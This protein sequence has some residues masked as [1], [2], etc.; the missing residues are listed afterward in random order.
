MPGTLP[1]AVPGLGFDDSYGTLTYGVRSEA[2]GF[3]VTTGSSVTVGQQGG[4][5][6][7][8]FLNIGSK[9]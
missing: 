7:T 3:E 2:F 4:N 5:D 6:A 1:Y 9:F 8:F